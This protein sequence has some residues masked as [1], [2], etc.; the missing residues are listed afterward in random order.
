MTFAIPLALVLLLLVPLPLLFWRRRGRPAL[1]YSH[2]ANFAA[3]AARRPAW[4]Q[5]GGLI[6]R[7]L[8]LVLLVIALAGP[9]WPDSESRVP[10]E[11][12]SIAM[13]VDVSSSMAQRDFL[14]DGKVLSR[15]EAVKKVFRLFLEGG[16]GPDGSQFS[17]RPQDLAALVT[18][19]GRPE[20]DCPL[21]LDHRALL[22]ILDAEEPREL[23]PTNPG[24]AIA[25]ALNRLHK[26]P[27]RHKAILFLTDGESN[28]PP[29]ALGPRA[30]ARLA[31]SLGVPIYAIEAGQDLDATDPSLKDEKG[32]VKASASLAELAQISGGMHFQA[33][34]SAALLE[35][36]KAMDRL[37]RDRIL[38]FEYRKYIDVFFWFALAAVMV[39]LSLAALESTWWR[40]SP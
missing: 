4:A 14:W 28:V 37:E 30:A 27:T 10:T 23:S 34:D 17:S 18:F 32:A 24:D 1:R 36:C 38:S 16:Q 21:T 8:G 25:W 11:G 3:P 6:L 33:L 2:G 12:I 31:A 15:L 40:T 35:A 7:G 9:R 19:A 13:V 29:P 26:A 39:W 5:W 20:T 22:E